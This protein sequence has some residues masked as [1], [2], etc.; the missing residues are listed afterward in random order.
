M[1]ITRTVAAIGLIVVALTAVTFISV[2]KRQNDLLQMKKVRDVMGSMTASTRKLNP[3]NARVDSAHKG[4]KRAP[5][6]GKKQLRD[7]MEGMA[8][9]PQMATPSSTHQA[10]PWYHTKGHDARF[11]SA[12]KG[13]KRAPAAP[14]S[15]H[16]AASRTS[17]E[18]GRRPPRIGTLLW[19]PGAAAAAAAGGWPRLTRSRRVFVREAA[20]WD[21]CQWGKLFRR[22]GAICW[23]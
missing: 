10:E 14:S 19:D 23:A 6:A 4:G 15:T 12:H 2:Q 20:A 13:G 1:N 7:V 18:L 5:A 16:Q 8:S 22:G 3:G 9:P 17:R 21:E 11:D